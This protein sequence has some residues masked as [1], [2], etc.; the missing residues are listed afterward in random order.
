M[1]EK[2]DFLNDHPTHA[3][4]RYHHAGF[5]PD[6]GSRMRFIVYSKGESLIPNQRI[7]NVNN[8]FHVIMW[9]GVNN[10]FNKYPGMEELYQQWLKI[11][12]DRNMPNRQRTLMK[13]KI[14]SGEL[15]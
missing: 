8:L 6:L 15:L 7:K 13:K 10:I 14:L 2:Q 12:Y 5:P 3:G 1:E 4:F 9:G 11:T